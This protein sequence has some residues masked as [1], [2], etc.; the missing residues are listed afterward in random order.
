MEWLGDGAESKFSA[1]CIVEYEFEEEVQEHT[2][3]CCDNPVVEISYFHQ[4]F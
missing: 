3:Y 2:N 4:Q 1:Y